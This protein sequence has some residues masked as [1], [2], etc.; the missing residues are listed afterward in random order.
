MEFIITWI[1]F[2]VGG[3]IGGMIGKLLYNRYMKMKTDI[4][5]LERDLKIIRDKLDKAE[6]SGFTSDSKKDI[7]RESKNEI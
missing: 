5:K 4:K 2:V 1:I 3:F 6:K 7:L